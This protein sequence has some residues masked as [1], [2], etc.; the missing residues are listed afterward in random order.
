[1]CVCVY[2]AS[3]SSAASGGLHVLPWHTSLPCGY[4]IQ[5][6]DAMSYAESV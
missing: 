4:H 2:V 6:G 3:H 1:V 5:G